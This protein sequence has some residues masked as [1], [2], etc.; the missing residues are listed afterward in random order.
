M[1]PIVIEA[2]GEPRDII[3]VPSSS[4]YECFSKTDKGEMV[5][6]YRQ[7]FNLCFFM[8]PNSNSKFPRQKRYKNRGILQIFEVVLDWTVIEGKQTQQKLTVAN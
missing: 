6:R 3:L 1:D 7:C 4:R 8:A 2:M 5:E